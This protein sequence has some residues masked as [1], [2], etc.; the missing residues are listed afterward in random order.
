MFSFLQNLSSDLKNVNLSLLKDKLT[1]GSVD[2]VDSMHLLS[3][4]CA[5]KYYEDPEW[6]ILSGRVSMKKLVKQHSI[7]TKFSESMK[8]LSYNLNREY[9]TFV[10][11]NAEK[12]D[13]MIVESRD[14]MFDKI[15][16]ETLIKSYLAKIVDDH[17]SIRIIETPQYMYLRVATY[18]HMPNLFEIQKVYDHLSKWEYT[19]ATPTLFNA[20][21]IRSAMSSCFKMTTKDSLDGLS[22]AWRQEGI[23]SKNSG[24]IG[25]DM[26]RIRHSKINSTSGMSKGVVPWLKIDEAIV[27]AVDQ[28]GKRN[29]S[30]AVYLKIWHTDIENFIDSANPNHK[31]SAPDLFYGL[32][33]CDLFMKR[34]R[35]KG[36]WSLF[37]PGLHPELTTVWG[38]KFEELY[39]SLESKGSY[40][41]QIQAVDLMDHI[42]RTQLLTGKPYMCYIDSMNRK[43]NQT[44]GKDM[45]DISNLCTEI[46]GVSNDD[47]IFSCNL[48]AITLNSCVT[49]R[50][51]SKPRTITELCSHYDFQKLESLTRSL[52][53]NLNETIDRTYYHPDIPQIRTSNFRRR[54]IG[55][56]VQGLADTFASLKLN[57]VNADETE[58]DPLTRHFHKLVFE[59]IYISAV[60]ESI[61]LAKQHG[62]YPTFPG[63]HTSKGFFQFDL[64]E[65]EKLG[66]S[67]E[68]YMSPSF[69]KRYEPLTISKSELEDLRINMIRHGI[70]NSLLIAL[71]PTASS[72]HI[73]GNNESFEPFNNIIYNRT[74]LSGTYTLI[75]KHFIRDAKEAGLWNTDTY[76]SIVAS[77][78]TLE[79]WEPRENAT[80]LEIAAQKE[81]KLRYKSIWD[82]KQRILVDYSADRSLFVCQS[83]SLNCH[84]KSSKDAGSLYK[85]L[86]NYHMYTWENKLK[87]GMYY[88]RQNADNTAINFMKGS[89]RVSQSGGASSQDATADAVSRAAPPQLVCNDEVCTMCAV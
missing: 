58:A 31:N 30:M 65:A 1:N 19:H 66:V 70:R 48:A 39:L 16:I 53:Q 72:A 25:K 83:Q 74:V 52:V 18:L 76:E 47:E 20:G 73:I 59:C 23:I 67:H 33:V 42:I 26:S 12:L 68:E 28:G 79:N 27:S 11:N 36:V 64:W 62:Q 29:G 57:W 61:E 44:S 8:L 14:M 51:K 32:M 6:L 55:I 71:M 86:K 45:V 75:N 15:G 9:A 4:M 88:L 40:S 38:E 43:C 21:F 3:D 78:C 46:T 87:T 5:A 7:P 69:T 37:C 60:R 35:E 81:L 80:F 54:P 2:S 84:M 50:P 34:V 49:S 13:N 41:K 89:I 22:T 10:Q 63:S 56:G 82:I 85:R 17:D 24:G 77:N